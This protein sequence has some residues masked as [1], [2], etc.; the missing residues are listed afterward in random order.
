MNIRLKTDSKMLYNNKIRSYSSKIVCTNVSALS[1]KFVST[2][3][4][5]Y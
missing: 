4:L 1:N 5:S 3:A 2:E